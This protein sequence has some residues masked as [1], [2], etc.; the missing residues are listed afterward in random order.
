MITNFIKTTFRNFRRFKGYTFI[1]IAG[2]AVGIASCLLIL[3][4]VNTELSYDRF[5]EKADQIYRVMMKIH[6]GANQ[7]DVTRGPCP[8]SEAMLKDFPEV[9]NSVRLFTQQSRRRTTYVRYEDNQFREEKFIWA[10]STIFEVF[11]IPFI[12]GNPKTA[13][14]EMNSVVIT[15]AMARK[16]FADDSPINKMIELEDGSLYKVTG[17]VEELPPNSHFHYDFIAS[18][19]SLKKS[20]DPDWY[21]TA[22][23]AYIVLPENY[24]YRQLNAKFPE[25]SRKYY[26][27]I[28][29]KTMGVS[30][31]QFLE[32]GNF[33]GFYLQPL[34]DIHLHST[35]QNKFESSGNMQTVIIFS[36][37]ALVILIVACVNF[38]NLATAR[39]AKRANE[40]VIRKV[41]GSNRIQLIGQFLTESIVVCAIAVGIGVFMVYLCLPFFNDL[42]GKSLTTAYLTD[43]YFLMG[44]FTG[45]VLVG[46]LAGIYPAFRMASFEP[47]SVLKGKNQSGAGGRRFRNILVVFQ[48]ATSIILFIGTIVIHNQLNYFQNK[49]LGFDQE[50]V[51]VIYSAEKLAPNQES[52]KNVLKQNANIV[53]AT[54]TDCLPQ[55]LLEVKMFQKEGASDN[56]NHT[57]ITITSDYDFMETYKPKLYD[58]RFFSRKQSTDNRAV[59]VN[60]AALKELNIEK[61][62]DSRLLRM[63][64]RDKPYQIIGVLEDFHLQSLHFQIQPLA[65]LF[66]QKRPGVLLS[67]RIQPR[68]IQESLQFIET[69]WKNFVPSQPLEYVFYD[70]N[71]ALQYN[72]EIR[73]GKV[74]GAFS[75]LAIFIACLGLFGIASFIAEQRTK[76]IGIRKVMGATIPGILINLNKESVKWVLI[77]NIIAWPVAYFAM[78]KWLQNFAYRIDIEVWIFIIA[79]LLAL[80]I[81]LTTVSFQS[82]KAALANPVNSLRYE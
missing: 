13:L 82:I 10:D 29:Q 15:P 62:L 64:Y 6:I 61:P 19:Q 81:A 18:F 23:Y 71:F 70:D 5:H 78:H 79:A 11:T 8:L 76:E 55:I 39:S 12:S 28:V 69:Q 2:L 60:Q 1:N 40:V 3:L 50:H 53:S 22:A 41:V 48:F 65:M 77:A 66:V 52:F 56:N 58:G 36:A 24:P 80:L 35:A 26:E 43:E 37:I 75:S 14:K 16:Y 9:E 38:I 33:F 34:T 7:F 47:V 4:F 72:S 68:T 32:S 49:E 25:F 17:L 20:R 44:I 21:D 45:T 63:D 46:I 54:Y 57:L 31:D 30:Y 67:V 73:A 51:L 59:V 42:I 27:P 74:F